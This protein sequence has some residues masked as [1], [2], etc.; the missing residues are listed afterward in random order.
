M[1][2]RRSKLFKRS[3]FAGRS[4]NHLRTADEHIGIVLELNA[5]VHQCWTVGCTASARSRNDRD[6]RNDSRCQN[7]RPKDFP[8]TSKAL[9]AFLD[10]RSTG[11]VHRNN[12]RTEFNRA[13]H[14]FGHFLRMTAAE[15]T[16]THQKILRNHGHRP[17]IHIAYSCHNAVTGK[18]LFFKAESADIMFHEHSRFLEGTR[19]YKVINPF[20]SGQKPFRM[21]SFRFLRTTAGGKSRFSA[22]FKLI[23]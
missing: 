15:G 2:R 5:E 17:T 12:R 3:L 8:I 18:M 14:G 21:T 22:F 7:I 9:D 19:I 23:Q 10:A 4:F 11:I 20:A 16:S 1:R 13:L 6:L